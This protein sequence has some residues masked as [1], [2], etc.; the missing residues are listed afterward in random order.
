MVD[1]PGRLEREGFDGDR[2]ALSAEAG[3]LA[4]RRF[5]GQGDF[6]DHGVRVDTALGEEEAARR[7]TYLACRDVARTHALDG[8][9]DFLDRLRLEAGT[10][11]ELAEQILAVHL[12]GHA[13]IH[14]LVAREHALDHL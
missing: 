11:K 5:E 9:T 6:L 12:V 8:D 2:L 14:F 4:A 10:G 1:P 13:E 7:P 3:P